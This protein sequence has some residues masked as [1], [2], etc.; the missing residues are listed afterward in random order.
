M[1]R[2]LRSVSGNSSQTDED[3]DMHRGDKLEKAKYGFQEFCRLQSREL[4]E[5]EFDHFRAYVAALADTPQD[6]SP[7]SSS[8]QR[9]N[10]SFDPV[11]DERSICSCCSTLCA[12]VRKEVCARIPILLLLM[13]L[14]SVSGNIL[15]GFEPF[16][17]KHVV[18]TFYL[19][20]L[21]GA[22][23]NA[24]NQSAVKV[25]RQ[26]ALGR[27]KDIRLAYEAVTAF[28]VA[29]LLCMGGMIRVWIFE[30]DIRITFAITLSLFCITSASIIIGA[31]LP[32]CFHYCKLDSAHAG[33]TIQ[34]VMDV[35]GVLIS[36]IVCS[37]M[38]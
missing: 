38:L 18:I 9:F 27:A 3:D 16:I 25:I 33:P 37:L 19:T 11:V 20:M 24:G 1:E 23:G 29:I 36:C 15:K 13:V 34:V 4:N 12:Y 22:G 2:R 28:A 10:T 17:Q 7:R 30:R 35:S 5:R 32:L 26:L 21:V 8:N 14:Q 6:F 31:V